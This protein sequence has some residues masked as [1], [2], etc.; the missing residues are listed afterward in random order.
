MNTIGSEILQSQLC[1]DISE[2]GKYKGIIIANDG[3]NFS[4][5]A[6]VGII[7]MLAVEQ[8]LKS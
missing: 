7:F 3:P 6:N 5:G 8:D 4:V 1:Y 2:D